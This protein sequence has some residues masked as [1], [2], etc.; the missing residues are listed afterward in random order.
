MKGL[1]NMSTIV[2]FAAMVILPYLLGSVNSSILIGKLFGI[3][4]IRKHGSGNAGATNTLRTIGKRAALFT[5]AGDVLK[6]VLAVLMGWITNSILHIDMAG[7]AIIAGLFVVVG[8]IF[9]IFFRFK[10]GKGVATAIGM[11]FML[12]FRIGL[13]LVVLFA[14]ALFLFR[15][16]SLGAIVGVVAYPILVMVFHPSE[17][18]F[19]ITSFCVSALIIFMHRSNIVRIAKGTENRIT[20][21]K[22]TDG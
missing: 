19:I 5:F 14:A 2:G 20:S 4:D 12:D 6:G 22:K 8:H 15:Y 17:G 3:N 7:L 9:P 13:I 16:V 21:K 1:F 11:I 10:G 18:L